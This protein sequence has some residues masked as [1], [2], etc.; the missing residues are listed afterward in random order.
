MN[1][2][3]LPALFRAADEAS[4]TQ[5]GRYFAA[6]A[7]ILALAVVAGIFGTIDIRAGGADWAAAVATISFVAGLISGIY[8]LWERPERQWYDA[9]AAAESVKT[10]AWR[11]SVG[12]SDFPIE[13]VGS[14]ADS[15]LV[16]RLSSLSHALDHVSL[17]LAP[18]AQISSRMRELR[19]A[20]FETR[21]AAYRERRIADQ[22]EWYTAAAKTNSRRALQWRLASLGAQ[23]TGV[24]G[25]IL[26]TTETIRFD[27]LGI[28]AAAV[29]AIL[30]W[31]QT[32]E[33][34]TLAEAYAVTARELALADEQAQAATAD[35]WPTVVDN[36]EAAVSRE[37]TLWRARRTSLDV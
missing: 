11:Y 25:G 29:A 2:S 31:L 17:A 36:T 15:E 23:L 9:R 3:D 5:R 8:I 27:L 6:T 14:D 20:D 19:N 21:R 34:A 7:A 26:R 13:P 12:G 10:L 30:A 24:I 28:A 35:D 4:K 37:H 16:K 18:G 33:H 1:N 32:R 22:R